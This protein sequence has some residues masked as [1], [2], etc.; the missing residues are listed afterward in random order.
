[1]TKDEY[2]ND[3]R[4]N[5]VD[6]VFINKRNDWKHLQFLVLNESGLCRKFSFSKE[7]FDLVLK[8]HSTV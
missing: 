5:R 1:M 6:D 7:N 4:D 8:R 3:G 2:I